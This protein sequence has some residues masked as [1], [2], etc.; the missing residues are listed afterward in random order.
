MEDK[1]LYTEK[2]L[3][4]FKAIENQEFEPMEK[5]ELAKQRKNWQIVAE[6]T[7]NKMKRKKRFNIRLFESDI[8]KLKAQA[9]REGLPYQTYLASIIHQFA[10]G[11]ESKN[12][13]NS[14]LKRETV[15]TFLIK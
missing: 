9:L 5:K 10:T 15:N 3:A 2:E 6:N 4:F 7:I 14:R 11:F 1:E 13:L 8:D 12:R